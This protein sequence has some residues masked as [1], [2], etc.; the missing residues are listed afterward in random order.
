[1][2][3]HPQ[4]ARDRNGIVCLSSNLSFLFWR[5]S[6]APHFSHLV[7]FLAPL[8]FSPLLSATDPRL[9]VLEFLLPSPAPLLRTLDPPH[10]FPMLVLPRAAVGNRIGVVA[11]CK[12]PHGWPLT[13]SRRAID[14]ILPTAWRL[15]EPG[16]ALGA[17]V[18][19]WSHGFV[20]LCSGPPPRPSVCALQQ[21]PSRTALVS[22]AEP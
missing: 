5:L 8:L 7:P 15:L 16:W 22:Y 11:N 10:L 9:V 2:L 20:H 12:P 3:L 1:M 14:L 18:G 13:P 17:H 21:H 19:S 6:S 4:A